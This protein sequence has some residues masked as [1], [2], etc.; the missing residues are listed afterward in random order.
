MVA[1]KMKTIL[2]NYR[3]G[4]LTVMEVPPPALAPGGVLVRNAV[5]LVSAGTERLMVEFA[6]KGLLGKARERPDLVRQVLSKARRDGIIST[7]ETVRTRLDVPVPLGYS[8]AGT[9]IAVG[10]GV[11]KFQPGDRVACA[12][13]GYASHAEIA[14]IPENLAVK[15]PDGV[16]F[17]S[18]AFTTLGAIALQGLRLAELE[19][20]ETVAVIGLGLLGILTVQLARASGC[21]VIGM[22]PN[23]ERCRLAKQFGIDE[24]V[25]DSAGFAGVLPPADGQ[26]RRRQGH[27]HRFHENQRAPGPG[28][29]GGPGPGRRGGRGSHGHGNPPE[30][31]F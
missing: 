14:F 6:R 19:L 18:A 23:P 30:N 2:Q 12:G 10:E 17:E 4:D 29:G 9:V 11:G 20:G 31:L 25:P 15:L 26:L 13:A 22:D 24:A 27:R 3:N 28:G 5:S 7:L 21:R 16:D 8:S 1:L